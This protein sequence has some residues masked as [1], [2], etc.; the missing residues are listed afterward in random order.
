[1]KKTVSILIALLLTASVLGVPADPVRA[2]E[3]EPDLTDFPVTDKYHGYLDAHKDKAPGTDD[4][5]IN[6]VDYESADGK[7]VA[8]E[9][10]GKR[11]LS[12]DAGASVTWRF[13]V[14]NEGLYNIGVS[15]YSLPGKGLPA[16][17]ALLLNGSLPFDD[18]RS[19]LFPRIWKDRDTEKQYDKTGN[20]I[21]S[22][23]EEVF[24]WSE[25]KISAN[26]G[27]Y[28]DP[29]L[30]YLTSGEHTLCLAPVEEGIAVGTIRIY[31]EKPAPKYEEYLKSTSQAGA[32]EIGGIFDKA[33]GEDADYKSDRSLYALYDQSS[34][35]TEPYDLFKIN[36]NYIGGNNWK[37][38][39]Q[40]LEWNFEVKES[41][42]YQIAFRSR[43]NYKS[44]MYAAR[45]LTIDGKIPFWEMSAV[46]FNYSS[47]WETAALSDSGGKPY[48][49]YLEEGIRT[50]RLECVSG[51]VADAVAALNR[52]VA[53][54]NTMYKSI[55]MLTG[56]NP[57]PFRDYE[58]EKHIP[59]IADTAVMIAND[60][61]TQ[62]NE[63]EKSA[64]KGGG[65]LAVLES[66]AV[67][68]EGLS[69]KLYTLPDRLTDLRTNL[70]ALA[71]LSLNLTQQPLD[72]DYVAVKSADT[73]LPNGD[74]G[75]FGR[76]WSEIATLCASFFKDYSAAGNTEGSDSISVWVPSGRDQSTILKQ[77]TDELFTPETD[78]AVQVS[79]IKPEVLMP[80]IVAGKGPDVI[81][82]APRDIPVN[83]GI[84]GALADLK[85]F[86]GYDN[87]VSRFEDS[88]VV[89]LGFGG[90]IYG[91]PETQSFQMMFVRKD[92][93]TELGIEPPEV[94]EDLYRTI[95]VLKKNNLEF[96]F[97]FDINSYATLL[98]QRGGS[99]YDKEFTKSALNDEKAVKAFIE[100]TSFRTEYNL[101]LTFDFVNRF[102]TGEMPIG[103]ADF[104]SGNQLTVFAPE[105]NGLWE[106]LPLPGTRAEDGSVHRES[107]STG[108]AV[109]MV[110]MSKNKDSA[111]AFIDWWLS[112]EVQKRFGIE[113]ENVLGPSARYPSANKEAFSQL[114]WTSRQQ[115]VIDEQ[116][117]WIRPVEE[118]PGG[119]FTPR[120]LTNAFR[121]VVLSGKDARDTILDYTEVIDKEITYKRNELKIK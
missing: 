33:Q 63:I 62:K 105:I 95:S 49:F 68:L 110:E 6:G 64:G 29:M 79:L 113:L 76:L 57:D 99:F 86:D 111:W 107:T 48:L 47:A 35:M 55:I 96:G 9:L 87:V 58:F 39:G 53:D 26:S 118:I 36:Y 38:T 16:E 50:I 78:T 13:T 80:A 121:S 45:R 56:V 37:K 8:G 30:F 109:F 100:W 54:L 88:A 11:A 77:L 71:A 108:S 2:I 89:P 72:I 94:W 21:R 31:S 12:I 67:Q 24:R 93:F 117:V 114:P 52:D 85:Q 15:Y 27:E 69:K 92:I 28:N 104:M 51:G 75:F 23:A 41:G 101:P 5:L 20:Q 73:E 7:A 40:W 25:I 119:Y 32:K 116:R 81:I 10:D 22:S 82:Q 42:L 1:M 106:M 115:A 44:G 34:P 43:Q 17:R 112:A 91:L 65:E 90:K 60:L 19:V 70:S 61:R 74:V 66:M 59:G 3:S 83:Y 97:P 14:A 102:K 120:H 4:I 84:R 98:F 103:M 18:M 46:Q